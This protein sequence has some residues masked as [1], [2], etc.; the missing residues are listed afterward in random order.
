MHDADQTFS[1]AA[2]S[3]A[4]SVYLPPDVQKWA[5]LDSGNPV[6]RFEEADRP[7]SDINDSGETFENIAI[8]ID[9]EL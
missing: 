1:P 8:L 3:V 2:T 9:K 7:L 4:D 6:V 5:G